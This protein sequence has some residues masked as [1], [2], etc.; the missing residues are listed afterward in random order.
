MEITLEFL[1]A[2]PYYV[3]CADFLL[4]YEAS[5]KIKLIFLA[6]LGYDTKLHLMVRLQFLAEW[7]TPII[8]IT[9]SSTLIQSSSTC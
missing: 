7:S 1:Q 8:A 4:K 5:R 2:G 3:I 6:C 9:L